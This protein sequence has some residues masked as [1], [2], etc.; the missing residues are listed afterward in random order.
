MS[1]VQF[2]LD[3]VLEVAT[4]DDFLG[5]V[6][7]AM[8]GW[9]WPTVQGLAS[10]LPKTPKLKPS[11]E[12]H[13]GTLLEQVPRLCKQPTSVAI[14]FGRGSQISWGQRPNRA[15]FYFSVALSPN[16]ALFPDPADN[17]RALTHVARRLLERGVRMTGAV[18]R[19]GDEEACVP[20]VPLA[21]TRR[22]LII[23][24]ADEVADEYDRPDEF[25]SAG[26][27]IE[28]F[29]DLRLLTRCQD[30]VRKPDVLRETQD[31]QWQM[32]RAA[33]PSLTAYGSPVV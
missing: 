26:W 31:P 17:V 15:T 13:L 9:A 25:W 5:H 18:D 10:P 6:R 21:K 7:F 8:E 29:G 11:P 20:F 3:T 23:A 14:G 16:D 4:L 28:T 24:T 12:A 22:P 27:T 32:A 33:K 1:E 2:D 30:V 19:L